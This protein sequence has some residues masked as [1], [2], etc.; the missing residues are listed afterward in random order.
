MTIPFKL[1]KNLI[2]YLEDQMTEGNRILTTYGGDD[3]TFLITYP[4][5]EQYVTIVQCYEFEDDGQYSHVNIEGNAFKELAKMM[6][7]ML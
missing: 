5:L 7:E 6:K 1:P 3:V 4:S 2:A